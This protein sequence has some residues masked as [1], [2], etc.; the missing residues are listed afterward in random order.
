[1]TVFLLPGLDG[2]GLLFGPLVAE[3]G[4]EIQPKVVAYPPQQPLQLDELAKHVLHQLP[5]EK[6]ILVAESFS[7]LVALRLLTSA[8]ARIAGIVF[9]GA[10]AEPPR[11]LLVRLAPLVSRSPALLRSAPAFLLRQ[12]CIGKDATADDLRLLRDAIAAVSPSVLAQRLALVGARHSFAKG[13]LDVPCYYLRARQDRLVPASSVEWFRSRFSQCEV[14][15]MDGP[16]F[17]LQ[18]KPRK[19]ARALERFIETLERKRPAQ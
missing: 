12:F 14:E 9:V 11:P 13:P 2:T 15:E 10:F 18:A 16:H 6:T 19:A 5:A 4:R 1:V 3:L 8:A 7:G 17:L